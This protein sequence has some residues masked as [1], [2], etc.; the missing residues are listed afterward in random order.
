MDDA[1]PAHRTGAVYGLAK[2]EALPKAKDDGWRTM[3]ITLRGNTAQVEVDGKQV[4]TFDSESKDLPARRSW[5]EPKR[6][7]KRPQSGYVGLQAH[8]PGDVGRVK[9]IS[10]RPLEEKP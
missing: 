6:D 4:T 8:D 10:V 3:V 1:D 9:E 7:A 5:T 2:A